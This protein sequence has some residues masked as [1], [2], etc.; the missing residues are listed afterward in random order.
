MRSRSSEDAEEPSNKASGGEAEAERGGSAG[1]GADAEAST[2]NP[3]LQGKSSN[4]ALA[5]ELTDKGDIWRD[6]R[7]A[8][9][10]LGPARP[11]PRTTAAA[12]GPART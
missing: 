5:L 3:M 9:L 10:A 4:T 6:K 1:A 2:S 8:K 7:G 11:G 12:L